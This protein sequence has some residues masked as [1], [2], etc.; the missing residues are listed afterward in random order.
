MYYL[1]AIHT[2]ALILATFAIIVAVTRVVADMWRGREAEGHRL[3][4]VMLSREIR[5][6][7]ERG[8]EADPALKQRLAALQGDEPRPSTARQDL[9]LR[10]APLYFAGALLLQWVIGRLLDQNVSPW[11]LAGGAWIATGAG[12]CVAHLLHRRGVDRGRGDGA[13]YAFVALLAVL[14]A[15]TNAGS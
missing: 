1:Q 12:I 3:A 2:V 14:S 10:L 5:R 13:A 7:S 11:T 15:L 6:Q 9:D 8:E 4:V